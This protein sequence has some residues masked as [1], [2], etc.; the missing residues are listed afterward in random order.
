MADAH[1]DSLSPVVMMMSEHVS[2]QTWSIHD[3]CIIKTLECIWKTPSMLCSTRLVIEAYQSSHFTAT[4]S[5]WVREL[6]GI[7]T[8]RRTA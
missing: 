7:S 6:R 2:K 8:L 5:L 3:S 4:P 1:P